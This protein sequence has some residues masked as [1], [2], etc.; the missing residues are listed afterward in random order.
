MCNLLF[1]L[2]WRIHRFGPMLHSYIVFANNGPSN[3]NFEAIKIF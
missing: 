3:S 2:K 1:I